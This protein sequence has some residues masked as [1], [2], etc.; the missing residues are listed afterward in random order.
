MKKFNVDKDILKSRIQAYTKKVD[1]LAVEILPDLLLDS[2]DQNSDWYQ[3]AKV[4]LS[5]RNSPSNPF[6]IY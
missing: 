1:K 2:S 4:E 3:E 5:R 6:L